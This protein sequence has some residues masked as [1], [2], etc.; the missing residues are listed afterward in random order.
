MRHLLPKFVDEFSVEADTWI[1]SQKCTHN[2][3]PSFKNFLLSFNTLHPIYLVFDSESTCEVLPS[4]QN[5]S[6]DGLLLF[7][8]WW[9]VNFGINFIVWGCE[10]YLFCLHFQRLN[11]KTRLFGAKI[12]QLQFGHQDIPAK[13]N[14]LLFNFFLLDKSVPGCCGFLLCVL[15]LDW[16]FSVNA[17]LLFPFLAF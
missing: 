10:R 5:F 17:L 12:H 6:F 7:T 16:G 8:T 15:M 4:L 11:N 13:L 3:L 14:S 2:L 9:L 1:L